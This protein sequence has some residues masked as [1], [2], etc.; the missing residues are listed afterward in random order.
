MLKQ[1]NTTNTE[2]QQVAPPAR[3]R[4]YGD[5][6]ALSSGMSS[7][8]AAELLRSMGPNAITYEPDT[9]VQGIIKEFAT[10]FGVY[11]LMVYLYW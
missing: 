11:S 6:L 10:P 8:R 2:K 4:T 3:I 7:S 1:G 5:V 9:F